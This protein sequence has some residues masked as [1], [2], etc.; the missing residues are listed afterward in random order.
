MKT[1]ATIALL[2]VG[3]T[4]PVVALRSQGTVTP[5]FSPC[6]SCLCIPPASAVTIPDGQCGI[7]V[8]GGD[9][10][11]AAGGNVTV[12]T[13][14]TG[15]IAAVAVDA[16]ALGDVD[17]VTGP[18]AFSV[19]GGT[20]ATAIVGG[21]G[22]RLDVVMPAGA[23]T[24]TGTANRVS[25]SNATGQPTRYEATWSGPASNQLTLNGHAGTKAVGRW[26]V[27]P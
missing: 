13:D 6:G 24:I 17:I 22:L 8:P 19:V 14:A 25:D 21:S 27:D 16:G 18:A 23:L 15:A 5:P 26:Y 7:T 4:L 10:V 9:T 3:L 1:L 20:G 11:A 2:A 12:S